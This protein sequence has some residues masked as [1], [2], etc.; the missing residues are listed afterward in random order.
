MR[1]PFSV[2]LH[3]T[4]SSSLSFEWHPVIG[5][6]SQDSKQS[7]IVPGQG[8]ASANIRCLGCDMTKEDFEYPPTYFHEIDPESF[9]LGACK[10]GELR[11][12]DKANAIAHAN[13]S[14]DTADNRWKLSKENEMEFK[15][16]TIVSP[17][18]LCSTRQLR[19]SRMVLCM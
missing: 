9:P 19:K 14:V 15:K 6:P 3:L 4:P 8:T 16:N 11:T 12:G 13:W 10:D 17:R 18:S 1:I 2:S 7:L 5:L